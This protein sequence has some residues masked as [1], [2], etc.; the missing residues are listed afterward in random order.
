MWDGLM[1]GSCSA[2]CTSRLPEFHLLFPPL[3]PLISFLSL[4]LSHTHTLSHTHSHTHT[5]TLSHTHTHTHTHTHNLSLWLCLSP[6]HHC[7]IP[8]SSMLHPF[9]LC[10]TEHMNHKPVFSK[11][12]YRVAIV[13]EHFNG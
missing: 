9:W 1:L 12:A 6:L 4:S 11:P 5:L 13:V 3:P 2:S 10:A 8:V 7:L